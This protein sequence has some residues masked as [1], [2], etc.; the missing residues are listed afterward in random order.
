M[1]SDNSTIT[2]NG[3][4]FDYLPDGDPNAK[5][6][7]AQI[8]NRDSGGPSF[9][10]IG[11]QLALVGLHSYANYSGSAPWQSYDTSPSYYVDDINAAMRQLASQDGV[12]GGEQVTVVPEP[13]AMILLG[14]AAVGIVARWRRSRSDDRVGAGGADFG[15]HGVATEK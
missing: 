8:E 4:E 7:D 10:A 6:G 5:P 12:G 13:S 3:Y 1:F 11:N 2:F 14:I 15:C 9:E